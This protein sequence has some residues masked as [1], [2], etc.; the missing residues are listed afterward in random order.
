MKFRIKKNLCKKRTLIYEANRNVA[1]SGQLRGVMKRGVFPLG[2]IE[3]RRASA[4]S[5][6]PE[7]RNIYPIETQIY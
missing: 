6:T 5:L 7:P 3:T 1:R 4:H 2:D